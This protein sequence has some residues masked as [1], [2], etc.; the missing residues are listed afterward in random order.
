MDSQP[1]TISRDSMVGGTLQGREAGPATLSNLSLAPV[2]KT[3]VSLGD[4][5]S[6]S[7]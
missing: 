5:G 2:P 4:W 6:P 7:C 3:Q 1:D